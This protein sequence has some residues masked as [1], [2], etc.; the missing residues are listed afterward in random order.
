MNNNSLQKF[1][2][3]GSEIR[4]VQGEDGEP[5]FVAKD[6]VEGIGAY[7]TVLKRFAEHFIAVLMIYWILLTKNKDK[8]VTTK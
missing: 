4:V 1:T 3:S 5:R 6:V 8:V 7:W 2:F